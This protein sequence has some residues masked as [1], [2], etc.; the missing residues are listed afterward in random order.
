MS[1]ITTEFI[2][3]SN[4]INTS[5]FVVKR[6]ENSPR[7]V[8]GICGRTPQAKSPQPPGA[9]IDSAEPSTAPRG[10][11]PACPAKGGK[12]RCCCLAAGIASRTAARAAQAATGLAAI[13]PAITTG[14]RSGCGTCS[15]RRPR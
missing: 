15:M 5:K 2:V 8:A 7:A 9:I 13:A 12:F 10:T 6:E 3:K 4:E 11:R 1:I 14:R